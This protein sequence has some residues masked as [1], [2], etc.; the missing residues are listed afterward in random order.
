[1]LGGIF[2]LRTRADWCT[3][4]L[5]QDVPHS[6]MYTTAEVPGD[7]QAQHLQ[8]FVETQHPTM[9][10]FRTVRSPVSFDGERALQV[11]APP[12]LGEHNATF[13]A[14]WPPRPEATST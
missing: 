4:L 12:V 1:V 9:G 13:K 10:N 7:P 3:R 8:L 11:T 6:P 2:C 14:G 5:V